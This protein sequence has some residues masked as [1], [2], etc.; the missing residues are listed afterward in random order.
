V[1]HTCAFGGCNNIVFVKPLAEYPD[2]YCQTCVH[3]CDEWGCREPH[4]KGS[5]KC[6]RHSCN[7]YG[8]QYPICISCDRE[9][10]RERIEQYKCRGLHCKICIVPE[11]FIA[12]YFMVAMNCDPRIPNTLHYV[13]YL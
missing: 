4:I 13:M 5:Y 2:P 12:M 9:Q 8:G 11:R 7:C 1:H 3:M 6:I 10:A